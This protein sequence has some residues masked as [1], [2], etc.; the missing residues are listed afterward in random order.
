MLVRL[1][2]GTC[3][4]LN[5]A[6]TSG[7]SFGASVWKCT[8]RS[9]KMMFDIRA[10][11]SPQKVEVWSSRGLPCLSVAVA[12]APGSYKLRHHPAIHSYPP[13]NYHKTATS[14]ATT[15]EVRI[16]APISLQPDIWPQILCNHCTC[17]LVVFRVRANLGDP[18]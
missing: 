12:E 10:G 14:T 18:H 2:K 4:P 13:S 1:L 17:S 5:L 9:W 11:I 15:P 8:K 6:E 7:C 16:T 3:Y